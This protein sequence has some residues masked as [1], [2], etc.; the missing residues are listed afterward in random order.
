MTTVGEVDFLGDEDTRRRLLRWSLVLLGTGLASVVLVM[1]IRLGVHG[2]AVGEDSAWLGV[3]GPGLAPV[4]WIADLAFATLVSLPV[5][6]LVHAALFRLLGG[7]GARVRFGYQDGML[8]AT[9]PGLILTR[10]RFCV[11]LAGPAVVVS[12][13]LLVSGFV[14]DVPLMGC[15]AFALHLPGCAGDLLA[16]WLVARTPHCTHCQDT[17][18]GVRL[19]G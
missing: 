12:A 8:Y 4:V 17:E 2:A 16:I 14:F 9:C 1:L 15:A 3:L 18:R 13:L 10:A 7:P 11:V 19:L 5:H 6:E